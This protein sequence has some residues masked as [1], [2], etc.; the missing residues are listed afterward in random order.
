MASTHRILKKL[1]KMQII[2]EINISKFKVYQLSNNE[3][4]IYLNGF[5]KTTPNI[6]EKFIEEI[7]D[8]KGIIK[9]IQHGKETDSKVNMLI[10]GDEIDLSK[11]KGFIADIKSDYD[12]NISYMSLTEEQYDQMSKMGLYSGQKRTIFEKQ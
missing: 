10:I 1:S 4:V 5:I 11:I 12:Y 9:V 8:I 2:D 3:R 6:I 7:K